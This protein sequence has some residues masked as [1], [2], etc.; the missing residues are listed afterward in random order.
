MYDSRL[1]GIVMVP[2]VDDKE[3]FYMSKTKT[4]IDYLAENSVK[5]KEELEQKQEEIKSRQAVRDNIAA[6]AN[7]P[8]GISKANS[9]MEEMD[10]KIEEISGKA[11][12][13][14]KE[15]SRYNSKN[16]IS[17]NVEPRGFLSRINL[18]P[19]IAI[20]AVF[21][22]GNVFYMVYKDRKKRLEE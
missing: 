15:Y 6:S 14:D 5:A 1:T 7:H 4:G 10:R 21:Y 3:K 19:S 18:F 8:S 16:Y 22:G 2:S 9:M 20:P 12:A 17:L 13:L 11:I